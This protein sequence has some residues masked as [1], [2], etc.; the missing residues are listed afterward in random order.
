MEGMSADASAMPNVY[1]AR[2]LLMAMD[3]SPSRVISQSLR[4]KG[5]RFGL[6]LSNG[7]DTMVRLAPDWGCCGLSGGWNV[8]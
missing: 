5:F 6:V 8:K 4:T 3:T 1:F 2:R 7:S